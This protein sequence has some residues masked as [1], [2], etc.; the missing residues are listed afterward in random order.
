MTACKTC[1]SN[2]V[3]SKLKRL[4]VK[5]H[6]RI[7]DLGSAFFPALSDYPNGITLTAGFNFHAENALNNF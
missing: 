5:I 4:Y 3:I 1:H 6:G 2:K 7:F